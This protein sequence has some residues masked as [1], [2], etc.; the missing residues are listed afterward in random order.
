LSRCS[1]EPSK[2]QPGRK[3]VGIFP[4]ERSS[5]FLKEWFMGTL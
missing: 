4:G 5:I 3:T 1:R 2:L